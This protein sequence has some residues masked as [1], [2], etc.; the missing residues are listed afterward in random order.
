MD[1]TV[2][3]T[4]NYTEPQNKALIATSF[5]CAGLTIVCSLGFLLYVL[6]QTIRRKIFSHYMSLRLLTYI[7][8]SALI[9]A[10]ADLYSIDLL[11]NSENN[12]LCVTQGI[13]IQFGETASILWTFCLS[14][15]IISTL[16]TKS[17]GE[18]AK[19]V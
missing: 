15:F 1:N 4:A 17:P 19:V 9:S 18:K 5:S 6:I 7:E 11:T 13:Q 12:A 10:I 8:I 3:S 16:L 2:W 14:F